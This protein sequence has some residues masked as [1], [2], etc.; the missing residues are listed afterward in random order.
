M[1]QKVYDELLKMDDYMKIPEEDRLIKEN[2]K[3]Y[4]GA[5]K[6]KYKKEARKEAIS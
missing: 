4:I 5:L 3:K 1:P 6:A 2:V